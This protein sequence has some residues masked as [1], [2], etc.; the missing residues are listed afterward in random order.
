MLRPETILTYKHPENRLVRDGTCKYEAKRE[1]EFSQ[2]LC[3]L[4]VIGW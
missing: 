3:A 4:F 2:I 1:N